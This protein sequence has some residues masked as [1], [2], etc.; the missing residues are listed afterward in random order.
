MLTLD[1][2]A[3]GPHRPAGGTPPRRLGSVRRTTS[4]DTH[5]P[6]GPGGRMVV[7]G[8]ARDL[9]TTAGGGAVA[10]D[11]AELVAD[12]DGVRREL[13]SLDTS[14]AVPRLQALLGAVVGPGFRARVVDVDP[15]RRH[16]HG[17]L[18]LLLDDLPGAALVSGYAWLRADV[19]PAA[20][21]S[22]HLFA[23]EDLC[24]GWASD[25]TMMVTLRKH[26]Q[27][28][29]PLG[30]VAPALA[31]DGDANAWHAL[32][33]LGPTATRRLR[34]IDVNATDGAPTIDVEAFF[35]DTYVEDDG[36]ETIMHEYTVG[37]TVDAR[38]R[39]LLDITADADV[40]PWKE[41]PAAT[42]S[43]GRLIGHGLGDLRTYVRETFVGTSTCTHLNDVLR[44]LSDVD[45][46][47]ARV[48]GMRSS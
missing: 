48:A 23:K 15:E 13:R 5:R 1:P 17:L 27:N 37:A 29:T 33:P 20:P 4:I 9:G 38:T 44:G 47:V 35:R 16:D 25:G 43:A 8:H 6:D 46:L 22:A 24:A 26:G 36:M 21:G 28:P 2:S 14:P 45:A 18:T 41:C 12:L 42:A 3:A 10:L 7:H 39:T 30:P 11:T 19:I 40:L 32:D 34:R 31:R